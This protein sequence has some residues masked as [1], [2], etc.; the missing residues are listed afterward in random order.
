VATAKD[1]GRKPNNKSNLSRR[2]V[3]VCVWGGEMPEEEEGR[4][5]TGRGSAIKGTPDKNKTKKPSP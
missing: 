3:R 2:N 1:E 4:G 5:A